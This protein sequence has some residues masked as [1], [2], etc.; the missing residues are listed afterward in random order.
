MLAHIKME[1]QKEDGAQDTFNSTILIIYSEALK[2]KY[3]NRVYKWNIWFQS[4]LIP[5]SS[6]MI[7]LL[8]RVNLWVHLEG[9]I[10]P[11][12]AA[13][14]PDMLTKVQDKFDYHTDMLC[15]GV[16]TFW[17]LYMKHYIHPGY[18]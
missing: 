8:E 5:H 11:A 3:Y 4:A 15:C 10:T 7:A 1:K 2:A 17:V 6:V 18:F 13:L 9:G 12:V 16:W 14:T